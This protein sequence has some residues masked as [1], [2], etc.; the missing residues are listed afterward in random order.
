MIPSVVSMLGVGTHAATR[1]VDAIYKG[2]STARILALV[3]AC[4]ASITFG[5]AMLKTLTRRLGKKAAVSF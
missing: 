3:F 5:L 4:G 1:V 2:F